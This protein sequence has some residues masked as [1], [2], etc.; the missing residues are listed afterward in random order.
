MNFALTWVDKINKLSLDRCNSYN[1]FT[2][3]IHTCKLQVCSEVC[4][5]ARKCD[6]QC[7]PVVHFSFWGKS[8]HRR[9]KRF[10]GGF[11]IQWNKSTLLAPIPKDHFM[12]EQ[13]GKGQRCRIFA[14]KCAQRRSLDQARP[15]KIPWTW[16]QFLF[17]C[18]GVS[19]W[20]NLERVLQP[21]WTLRNWALVTLETLVKSWR[22]GPEL[23]SAHS[24]SF[25]HVSSHW[26]TSLG[27]KKQNLP[28]P[29]ISTTQEGV[30]KVKTLSYTSE[31]WLL[32][33]VAVNT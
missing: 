6:R 15:I 32:L 13:K 19:K 2:N 8:H 9:G 5:N 23:I 24:A 16:T 31:H 18:E 10:F 7:Q 14:M 26:L 27:E 28:W 11:V 3:V 30:L 21:V 25:V 17:L 29:K 12:R 22:K 1:T 4:H 33:K 20:L